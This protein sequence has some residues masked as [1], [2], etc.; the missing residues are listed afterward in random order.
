MGLF[1][2]NK[3]ELLVWQN[4]VI[5][6][7]P[8]KLI[9]TEKQLKQITEQQ[10]NNDLRIIQDCIKIISDTTKPDIFFSRLDLL[11][12]KSKHL[13]Q[14]EPYIKFSGAS[15]TAAFNEVL[16]NEQDAIYQFIIRYFGATFEKAES[17]KTEKGKRNQYRKFFDSLQ[18]YSDQMDERNLKYIEYKRRNH[19]I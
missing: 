14:L 2:R 13:I 3:K 19:L 6:D 4:L 17:L 1:R 8:N 12:E 11:K 9:V 16:T 10:A 15:P 18:P 5:Q 7:S